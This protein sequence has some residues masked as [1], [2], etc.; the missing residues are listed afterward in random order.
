[1]RGWEPA[2]KSSRVRHVGMC[3]DKDRGSMDQA[4]PVVLYVSHTGEWGGGAEIFLQQVAS[5]ARCS[6]YQ[7]YL[8]GPAGDL[9]LRMAT[10]FDGVE[11]VPIPWFRRTFNPIALLFMLLGWTRAVVAL[12][13]VARQSNA[14]IIHA[15]SGVAAL[16]AWLPATFLQLPLIWHQHDVV[17]RRCVNRV[18]LGACARRCDVLLATS[19]TVAKSLVDIGTPRDRIRT[20]Y[21]R[22]RPD[23]GREVPSKAVCRREL[24]LPS[25]DTIIGII[26]RLVPRKGH[27]VFL[28]AAARLV[29]DGMD[30]HAVILGDAPRVS[31]ATGDRD[32]YCAGLAKLAA[33]PPLNGRVTF[34]P[35]RD[36]VEKVLAACD[37]LVVPSANE[38][39]GIVIL[40]AFAVGT[41]VVASRAGG[42]LEIIENDK[43]GLLVSPGDASGF[44]SAI[45]CLVEDPEL[46]ETVVARARLRLSA[47]FSEEGLAHEL[48]AIYAGLIAQ[49]SGPG[50]A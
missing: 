6:G 50:S 1:M 10:Q 48:R 24:G 8:A 32:A 40:E 15:N 29:R 49:R 9:M 22:I 35:H 46:R 25:G 39:F 4:S 2:F 5:A 16:A 14:A 42:P 33:A 3:L 30:L 41:P 13:R 37:V 19:T 11:R 27:Q 47:D 21:P 20:F 36:D 31:G 18:V 38:P 34:L 28:D 44:A 26:G 17:P 23:F 12:V 45:G 7:T 43:T